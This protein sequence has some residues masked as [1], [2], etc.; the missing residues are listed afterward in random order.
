MIAKLISEYEML[1]AV[2]GTENQD[3]F[4]NMILW[5]AFKEF[6][7]H[8]SQDLEDEKFEGRHMLRITV[9]VHAEDRIKNNV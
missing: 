6:M 4:E 1:N 3:C 2:T 7:Q 8:I 9:Q 5:P